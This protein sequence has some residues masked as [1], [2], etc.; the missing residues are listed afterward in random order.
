MIIVHGTLRCPR[1]LADLAVEL[2]VAGL[3]ATTRD[4]SHYAGGQ[5]L[6]VELEGVHT[7]LERI[8]DGEYLCRADGDSLAQ[9]SAAC[10]RLSAILGRLH[11]R[12]RLELYGDDDILLEEFGAD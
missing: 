11:I 3:E 4:S 6:R 9:V 2:T 5:Y 10:R 12:H 8:A 1:P 7:T